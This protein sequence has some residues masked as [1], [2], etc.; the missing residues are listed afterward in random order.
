MFVIRVAPIGR[1]VWK[2]ELTFFSR[3]PIPE[4]SMVSAP[5]RGRKIHAIVVSSGEA[6]E[7]KASIRQ[8]DF[9]LKKIDGSKAK[10]L[11]EPA[12]L[13]AVSDTARWHATYKG[14]VLAST[15]SDELLVSAARLGEASFPEEKKPEAQADLLVLQAE[16][17]ERIRT[18]RNIAREAFARGASVAILSPTIIEA[19]TMAAELARGIEE[20]VITVTS[21]TTKKKLI[22][23][24][25]RAASELEPLLFI[26]TPFCLSLPRA[27]LDTV[28]IER[29]S[30]RSYRA[31]KHPHVDA[32]RFAEAFCRRKGIRLI[33]ADF[34][35]R[36]ET[37]YRLEDGNMS[38]FARL[39]ARPSEGAL[40]EVVDARK[41]D[42]MMEGR[43][44]KSPRRAFSALSENSLERI[45]TTLAEGGRI[46][47]F[48]P[49]KGLAPLTV[50]ND[51][52]TPVSDP[53]TGTPMTLYRSASGN[54]FI[55]HRSGAVIPAS[56]SCAKCGGWNLVTLGIGIER[57]EEE[58]KKRFP[59]A[60]LSLFTKESV[61][62]HRAA[63]KLSKIFYGSGGG[64]ALGT[65]RMLPYLSE[66]LELVVSASVDSMLSLSAWRAHE[67]ALSI[68]FY[69]RERAERSA[70][71]ETRKPE[72][73][74]LR[75]FASGNTHDFYR[76]EIAERKEY[77][78]PPFS[79]FIG[80]VAR[81]Q[82]DKVEKSRAL[83]ASSFADL[84][85]V[86]PLPAVSEGKNEYAA[87]AVIRLPPQEWP[88][89][90]LAA[91]LAE[92]PP[93]I[94]ATVDPDEI[95]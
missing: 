74:V 34:P 47:V 66:P 13:D 14:A 62:S 95:A 18:Y 15:L 57:V 10:R 8:A 53:E 26:G 46:A 94:R 52:G 11:F 73:P 56:V 32:R 64:I 90:N 80:L 71:V 3:S 39:Q 45:G 65:E 69:L 92:L 63:K 70:I 30:A 75:A 54:V 93:E 84:D 43:T 60:S 5:V 85:L 37:R 42:Q 20:R 67:H 40:A 82:R 1:G 24:W 21:E 2:D 36:V 44:G 16:R 28:I 4:G 19:E 23:A 88:Q 55:S 78:Y 27:D 81:G 25:N 87:H 38:E 86:G 91:R 83:I 17:N 9:A 61:P 35:V 72:H 29:E 59:D 68:L 79:V 41:K 7:E 76:T 89:K 31:V 22:E 49:R 50:C 58:L 48:A 51:C 77:S 12:F 6:R 33:L